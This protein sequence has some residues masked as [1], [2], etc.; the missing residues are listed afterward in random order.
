MVVDLGGAD[1]EPASRP[2]DRVLDLLDGSG[3]QIVAVVAPGADA[4]DPS[5]EGLTSSAGSDLRG[6][7]GEF[8]EGEDASEGSGFE[9]HEIA[10]VLDLHGEYEFGSAQPIPVPA[11]AAESFEIT[12]E[13]GDGGAGVAVRWFAFE[14]PAER[15][16]LDIG[17]TI[18]DPRP[19]EGLGHG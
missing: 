18:D 6:E 5:C 12:A 2:A 7:P 10:Y 4:V 1:T 11:S 17:G 9:D 16:D 14:D 13:F 15:S 8:R 3:A 19:Q